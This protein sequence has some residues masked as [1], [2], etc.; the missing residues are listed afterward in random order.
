MHASTAIE[1]NQPFLACATLHAKSWC[2]F[3]CRLCTL[4][5]KYGPGCTTPTL[6]VVAGLMLA[7]TWPGS[8]FCLYHLFHYKP[9]NP[10]SSCLLS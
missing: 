2:L 3:V 7:T 9:S 1:L 10:I 8:K 5:G 6:L 4:P